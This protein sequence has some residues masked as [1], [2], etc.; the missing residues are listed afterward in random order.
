MHSIASHYLTDENLHIGTVLYP[1]VLAG[2][3]C[4]GILS[5]G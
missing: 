4:T 1:P 5:R 2:E 3:T